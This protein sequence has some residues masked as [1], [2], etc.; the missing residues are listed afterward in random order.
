M[1]LDMAL[2][3]AESNQSSIVRTHVV[4]AKRSAVISASLAPAAAAT[5]LTARGRVVRVAAV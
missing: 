5:R 4:D 2:P 3:T 1:R